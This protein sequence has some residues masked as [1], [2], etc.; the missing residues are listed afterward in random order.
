MRC[1]CMFLVTLSNLAIANTL[2]PD[3]RNNVDVYQK[4]APSV[5]NI[6]AT[7]LRRDFFFEIVPQKGMGSGAILR[8]D[9]YIVTND[10][11][12]GNANQ[13]E[14]TF[15]DK[16]TAPAK[17]VGTDPDSDIAVLKVDVPNKKLT[18]LDWGTAK[19]LAVGQKALA[20]GNPFGLGGSLSTGVIS[21]LGRDIRATTD[22]LIK[23]II[24]TDAAINPG[25]SGGPLLD[26]AGKFIGMNTQI[27]S[28]S[29]G[30]DGIGFAISVETVRKVYEQLIQYGRVLRPDLGMVGVGLSAPLLQALGVKSE[31]GVMVT[32]LE[33]GGLA[34]GAGLKAADR[35][36][37]LGFRRFPYGGDVIT[38][39]DAQDISTMRDLLDY[40]GD[41]KVGDTIVLQVIRGGKKRTVSLKLNL[42]SSLRSKSL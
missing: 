23:D 41:K 36:V 3:E 35:E 17:V 25:N 19:T 28:S 40:I 15:F 1:L 8:S 13:V 9:G 6:T 10:H 12:V 20:I 37:V 29:G 42:P 26:S 7:T 30:S 16:S 39:V 5:V 22:R 33:R 34:A 11:V 32:D 38:K 27:V 4:C 21:S 14:V 24:Q 31:N 18:A 2:L